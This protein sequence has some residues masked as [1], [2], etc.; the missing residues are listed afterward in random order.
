MISVAGGSSI[1]SMT[2][3]CPIG[4]WP[5]KNCFA[6]PSL[7]S[8]T[9][10]FSRISRSV[11][12]RPA[13]QRNAHRA[14][15]AVVADA[16]LGPELLAGRGH[17]PA[18]DREAGGR[19]EAREGK[20]AHGAGFPDAG[21]LRGALDRLREE[22]QGRRILLVLL[23][24]ERDAR[25]QDALA[26]EARVDAAQRREALEHQARADQQNDGEG[27]LRDDEGLSEDAASAR[28]R[29]RNARRP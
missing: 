6:N 11:K 10:V 15:V 23:A 22:A 1:M 7:T 12:T 24:R 27:D 28:W 14:E 20:E 2:S 25:R 26:L 19:G 17:G 5:G 8:T 9:S 13:Q 29:L 21:D 18:D 16:D 4:S 3:L